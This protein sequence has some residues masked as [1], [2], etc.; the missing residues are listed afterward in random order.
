MSGRE[1]PRPCG[2]VI[3]VFYDATFFGRRPRKNFEP[4]SNHFGMLLFS[5]VCGDFFGIAA[6]ES[7]KTV[8]S[9]STSMRILDCE[10]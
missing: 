9:M 3:L 5:R 2:G 1:G 8:R 7:S 10:G 6:K 4:K